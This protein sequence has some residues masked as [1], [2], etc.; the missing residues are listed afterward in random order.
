MDASIS[1][2]LYRST[3]QSS[4]R[5]DGT[6]LSQRD[7]SIIEK[8]PMEEPSAPTQAVE[9]PYPEQVMT[10]PIPDQIEQ[11]VPEPLPGSAIPE[12]TREPMGEMAIDPDM[13][14][15]VLSYSIVSCHIP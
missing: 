4:T 8:G 3:A 6:A 5:L 11:M 10:E 7:A 12:E 9:M 14:R 13:A 2:Y 15:Q 1:I